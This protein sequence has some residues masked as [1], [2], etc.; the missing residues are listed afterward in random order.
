MGRGPGGHQRPCPL[1]CELSQ[2]HKLP[3]VLALL[4]PLP[5]QHGGKHFPSKEDHR[6]PNTVGPQ[7]SFMLIGA[8]A[9]DACK[10]SALP[11]YSPPLPAL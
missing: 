7:S 5:Y 3:T 2:V 4:C 8:P 10:S 6:D 11:G 9:L 1:H